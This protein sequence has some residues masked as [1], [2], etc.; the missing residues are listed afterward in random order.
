MN[1][2][3]MAIAA[4]IIIALIAGF[5]VLGGDDDTDTNETA[6]SSQTE[7][8]TTESQQEQEPAAEEQPENIQQITVA[9]VADHAVEEDC[10]TIIGTNVY[11]ITSYVPRHPGGDEILLACGSDGTSL[12]SNRMTEDGEDVGSGTPHSGNATS[13]LQSLFI[14]QLA[15]E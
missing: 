8:S 14:G 5:F 15:A 11:D 1:K 9:T 13:Q 4:A 10:W 6:N 2:T 12:F 7:N 3:T